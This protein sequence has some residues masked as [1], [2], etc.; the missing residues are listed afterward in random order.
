[1]S[2]ARED[3]FGAL[4]E[5]AREMNLTIATIDTIFAPNGKWMRYLNDPQQ[6]MAWQLFEICVAHGHK[7]L[8]AFVQIFYAW[9]ETFCNGN[10]TGNIA[11]LMARDGFFNE[12]RYQAKEAMEEYLVETAWTRWCHR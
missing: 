7:P 3:L 5:K 10:S 6:S 8:D 9:L 4:K 12:D 11:I 1:M 2:T